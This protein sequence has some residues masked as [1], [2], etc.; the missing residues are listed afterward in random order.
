[1]AELLRHP[2]W[3]DR[4]MCAA[5]LEMGRMGGEHLGQIRLPNPEGDDLIAIRLWLVGVPETDEGLPTLNGTFVYLEMTEEGETT[6]HV[7]PVPQAAL[8]G[9]HLRELTGAVAA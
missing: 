9:R 8:L 7:I 2:T 3:C 5:V 4:K 1:M 6:H